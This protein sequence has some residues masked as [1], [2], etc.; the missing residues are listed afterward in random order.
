MVEECKNER[1]AATTPFMDVDHFDD[2]ALTPG[3]GL[4]LADSKLYEDDDLLDNLI[5]EDGGPAAS[6]YHT[7]RIDSIKILADSSELNDIGRPLATEVK[8]IGGS[9]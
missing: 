8:E 6:M 7:E 2:I 3:G 9:G 4:G 5:T 1:T